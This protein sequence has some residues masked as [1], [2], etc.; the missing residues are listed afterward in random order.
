MI[1]STR[2][3]THRNDGSKVGKRELRAI[4]TRVPIAFIGYSLEGPFPEEWTAG[5]GTV[6]VD[7]SYRLEVVVP[8]SRVKE[9]RE[10]FK[11]IGR[12]LGQRATYFDVRKGGEIIDLEGSED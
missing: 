9:I 2:I 10:L 5:D 11:S 8:R 12:Q 1:A 3:P 4:L 7:E 6:Y